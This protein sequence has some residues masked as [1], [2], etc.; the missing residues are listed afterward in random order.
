MSTSPGPSLIAK[1]EDFYF[2][3][4][5]IR[6]EN[7]L[8]KIPR[9]SLT[10]HSEVFAD[11]FL[12]NET[13]SDGKTDANPIVLSGHKSADFDSL[14]TVLNPR[15]T[16]YAPDMFAELSKDGWVGVLKLSTIW[17]MHHIRTL[18]I[19]KLS[20]L[21]LDAPQKIVLAREHKV[22]PW[23]LEGLKTLAQNIT[24]YPV[25]DIAG[26]L[27]WETITRILLAR[28]SAKPRS[29]LDLTRLEC[30][31]CR[32]RHA[33]LDP[34]YWCGARMSLCD[35]GYFPCTPGWSANWALPVHGNHQAR[36]RNLFI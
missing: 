18:A 2:E 1:S 4:V 7:K 30:T 34:G 31:K 32:R 21:D 35:W 15:P 8:Y 5:T 23:F 28:D 22:P 24:D 16:V 26:A 25:G 19:K 33:S 27:G 9:H 17:Q 36:L 13:A 6:V 11:M 14:L 20:S 29:M 10:D 12:S 3:N